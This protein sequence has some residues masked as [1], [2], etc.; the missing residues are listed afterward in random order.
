MS[1]QALRQAQ[2]R[3]RRGPLKRPAG[4]YLSSAQRFTAI[5]PVIESAYGSCRS[6]VSLRRLADREDSFLIACDYEIPDDQNFPL[7]RSL[8]IGRL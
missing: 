8:R 7:F 1:F 6:Q 3:L 5:N 2:G 4:K